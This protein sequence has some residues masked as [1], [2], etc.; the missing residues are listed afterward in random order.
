[1]ANKSRRWSVIWAA[2]A[3]LGSVGTLLCCALPAVLVTL[4][5]GAVLAGLITTVP[6]LVMVSQYKGWV[7]IVAGVCLSL[8]GYAHW[9]TRYADC[10]VDPQQARA[11]QMLR[12]ISWAVLITAIGIYAIGGFFA[13]GASWLLL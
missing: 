13:F 8:A 10:P 7:F 9:R 12:R 11:C 6:G 1:M 3:L 4:G 5:M 2:V